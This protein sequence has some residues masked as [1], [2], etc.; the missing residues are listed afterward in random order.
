VGL[1]IVA[2]RGWESIADYARLEPSTAAT[3]VLIDIMMHLA[4]ILMHEDHDLDP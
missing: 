1:W 3:T 2:D 4:Y